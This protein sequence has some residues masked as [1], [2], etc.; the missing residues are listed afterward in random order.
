VTAAS[1]SSGT[2]EATALAATSAWLSYDTRVDH[3][4]NDT[5]RRLALP[6]LAPQ[7]RR[8]VLGFAGGAPPGAQW[9]DW[10]AHHARAT[11]ESQLGSDD[12]PPDVAGT[13]WRQ[14]IAAVRLHGDGGWTA[15]LRQ[16]L[17]VQLRLI[18]G[19]WLV[20]DVRTQRD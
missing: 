17:F 9:S 19:R 5:A 4:P 7:L 12:H 18:D 6:W 20:S 14:V 8:G 11:V 16:T 1:P 13:A 10:S 2:P 15:T 3:R